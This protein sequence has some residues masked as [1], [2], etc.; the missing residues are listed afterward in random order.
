MNQITLISLLII[1]S[2]IVFVHRII[3]QF[4][5]QHFFIHKLMTKIGTFYLLFIFL[6]YLK[7]FFHPIQ[8][9]FFC[10]SSILIFPATFFCLT[11]FHQHQ[12]YSEFLRFL[13]LLVLKMQ[14]GLGFRASYEQTLNQESWSYRLLLK[15]I[16]DNVTFS[17]QGKLPKYRGFRQFI[18]RIHSE[19]HAV[20]AHPHRAIDR[21]CNFR[22][23]LIQE[24]FFRRR[25]RQ[26][27]L[28]FG[29]QLGILSLIYWFIFV[30]VC[31][32]Y[33]FFKYLNVFL[34][35]LSL[36]FLGFLILFLIVRGKKWRI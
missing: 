16:Y 11:Q 2:V 4:K 18:G 28:N 19:L 30:Y 12:F 9:W 10:F 35:S 27:W 24:R 14:M 32:Q 31:L 34:L 20:Q 33:G 26:I 5:K 25:S 23:Q 29:L 7:F 1:V 3:F 8:L 17:Q 36:Y 6:L 22:D 13:T 15:Q 21:L